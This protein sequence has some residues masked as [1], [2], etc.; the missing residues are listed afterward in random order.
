MVFHETPLLLFLFS[1]LESLLVQHA[2]VAFIVGDLVTCHVL[3]RLGGAAAR[4]L[5]DRQKEEQEAAC[6]PEAK[7]LLV[8]HNFDATLPKVLTVSYLFNPYIILNCAAR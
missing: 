2:Q 4:A 5:L 1:S 6:H 3:A 7:S 8:P